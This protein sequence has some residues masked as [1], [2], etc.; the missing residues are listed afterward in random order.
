MDDERGNMMTEVTVQV[1][2]E[3]LKRVRERTGIE[4]DDEAVRAVLNEF[5][6][7]RPSGRKEDRLP[8]E[9]ATSFWG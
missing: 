8:T 1:D 6:T 3:L 2:W 9:E 4:N 5:L 7:P